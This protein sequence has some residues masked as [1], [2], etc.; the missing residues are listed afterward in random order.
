MVR[1]LHEKTFPKERDVVE[2]AVQVLTVPEKIRDGTQRTTSTANKNIDVKLAETI[3][4][5]ERIESSMRT[6]A[7]L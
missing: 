7:E 2:E 5:D 1:L 4:G 6:K 3:I